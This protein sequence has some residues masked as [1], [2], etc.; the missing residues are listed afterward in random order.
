MTKFFNRIH[1]FFNNIV[2]LGPMMGFTAAFAYLVKTQGD[3]NA[4]ANAKFKGIPFKFRRRDISAVKE[5]LL[6]GE[7]NFLRPVIE[8]T[9]NPVILDIG[10]HIGLFSIW[11]L[12]INQHCEIY[13]IEASPETYK[14]LSSNIDGVSSEISSWKVHH[15]AAWGHAG[16]ISFMDSA[17]SS[18]SHRV[19]DAGN[20][21]V[22]TITLDELMT[23]SGN[24]SVVDI[25]K[26]D[27]EGAEESFLCTSEFDFK[28]F[29][30][31]VI[32]V[33]PNLCNSQKVESLLRLNFDVQ[34]VKDSSPKS[35]PVFYCKG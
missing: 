8:K 17:E 19:G 30:N 10:A 25:I 4:I 27:I 6:K 24:K 11:A 21:A 35:K 22:K 5:V 34:N 12:S 31:L 23:V 9:K 28:K 16:A 33:H 15:R 32:E 13:S 1:S 29:K 7:Y 2:L 26:I 14:I 3:S 18:M 20:I